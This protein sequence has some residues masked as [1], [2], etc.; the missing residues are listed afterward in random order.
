MHQQDTLAE[1][2][3]VKI[4]NAQHAIHKKE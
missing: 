3:S 4:A 1:A 2:K